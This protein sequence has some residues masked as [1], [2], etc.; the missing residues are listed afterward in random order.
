L[1]SAQEH[2]LKQEN[3]KD[4]CLRTVRELSQAFALAVPHQ[5]ALRIRDDVASRPCGPYSLSARPAMRDTQVYCEGRLK[6]RD[7]DRP[8]R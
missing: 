6:P 7:E 8:R 2:I 1:P 4:R 3:G 5:D